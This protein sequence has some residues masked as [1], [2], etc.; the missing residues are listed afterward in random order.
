[1]LREIINRI[2]GRKEVSHKYISFS[3]VQKILMRLDEAIKI[4]V[5]Y[6]YSG[7]HACFLNMTPIDV[8]KFV[9]KDFKLIYESNYFKATSQVFSGKGKEK[10]YIVLI[11]GMCLTSVGTEKVTSRSNYATLD[12]IL[13]TK[14]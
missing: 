11:K 12:Y 3:E 8:A 14:E 4:N 5:D 10:H 13:E 9:T 6:Y 7:R 2:A 1:M